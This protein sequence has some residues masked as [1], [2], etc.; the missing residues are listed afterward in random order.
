MLGDDSRVC[1]LKFSAI[2]SIPY[3]FMCG[4]CEKAF[5]NCGRVEATFHCSVQASY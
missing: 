3:L 2:F 1:A 4:C 5:S